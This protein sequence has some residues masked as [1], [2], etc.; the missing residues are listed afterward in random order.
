MFPGEV[1]IW[2]NIM[3]KEDPLSPRWVAIIQ[4]V[5]NKIEQKME[6]GQIFSVSSWTGTFIFFLPLDIRA[7]GPLTLGHWDFPDVPRPHFIPFSA[8]GPI[9]NY[10]TSFPGSLV[11]RGQIWDF[12][13]SI[14]TSV[15]VCVCVCVC[16]GMLSCVWLCTTIWTVAF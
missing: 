4:S 16:T 5:E 11:C 7:P 13:A 9:L 12:A 6:E 15:C 3:G 10:T 1:S 14:T 8:F 2:I